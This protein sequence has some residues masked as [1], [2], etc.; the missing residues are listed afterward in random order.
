ME[1]ADLKSHIQN[2]TLESF[3]IFAGEEWKVQEIYINQIAKVKNKEIKRIDSITD[4]YSS[5][6]NTALIKK[7]FL[8]VV[9]D[10]KELMTNEKIQSQLS[11]LL[12]DD[13]LILVLTT[14]DKRLKFYK[15]YKDSI[16][17]FELLN[18]LILRKYIQKEIALSD[19]NADKLIEV[20]EGNYGRCVLEID[21][22]NNYRDANG[23]Y[24]IDR[25]DCTA[26]IAFKKLLDDGTIAQPTKDAIFDF[27][28][29]ILDNKLNLVYNLYK[30]CID[31]GEAV[32]V[33]LTVLYNNAKAVL[34]VQSCESNDIEKST[35]LTSWQINNARKHYNKYRNRELINIMDLC[36]ECQKGIVTG[37]IEEEFVMPYI[38]ASVL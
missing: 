36:Y 1:I 10:D 13:M 18:P 8:Y 20:C 12:K 29:A 3:Y 30:E 5:L 4:V 7:S 11:S 19:K 6:R 28:D 17:E 21:K 24:D 25:G 2:N 35:G 15:T 31:C 37:T 14:L 23:L 22:I 33:M 9:R 27:V 34:Q 16:V 38:M 32:M 26:D